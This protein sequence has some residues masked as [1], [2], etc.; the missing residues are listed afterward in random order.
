MHVARNR[1]CSNPQKCI[2]NSSHDTNISKDT[3]YVR[4]H[5]R[6]MG[7]RQCAKGILSWNVTRRKRHVASAKMWRKIPK[8]T[9]THTVWKN[10][11]FFFFTLKP[12]NGES[13]GKSG[14]RCRCRV[15]IN[16][17]TALHWSAPWIAWVESE[18]QALDSCRLI[19]TLGG[20]TVATLTVAF[21]LKNI[22]FIAYPWRYKPTVQ[23]TLIY[24]LQN[25]YLKRI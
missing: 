13:K 9:Q 10:I 18:C 20:D 19:R 22:E 8:N 23:H 5:Y 4:L 16:K 1:H 6:E 24:F 17:C 21:L 25:Q 12:L 14:F 7:V 11:F 3:K 2:L 15:Q